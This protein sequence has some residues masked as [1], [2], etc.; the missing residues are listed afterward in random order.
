VL[1]RRGRTASPP[2][3]QVEPPAPPVFPPAMIARRIR[4]GFLRRGRTVSP[5]WAQVEPPAPPA[6]PAAT[7]ARR[8]RMGFWR[9]GRTSSPPWPQVEPPAP[10]AWPPATVVRRARA[11]FARRGRRLE[12]PAAQFPPPPRPRGRAGVGLWRRLRRI[13]FPWPQ[14][15]QPP[16]PDVVP[17]R[18][19]LSDTRAA[20]VL[21]S[22]RAITAY[23]TFGNTAVEP[24][25]Q[26]AEPD[27]RLICAKFSSPAARRL[28]SVT[29]RLVGKSGASTE[30]LVRL[31]VYAD[32][33]GLPGALVA[34]S[35]NQH[36]IRG[37]A[38][39]AWY[40][41]TFGGE[42]L[43]AADYWLTQ[44]YGPAGSHVGP[45]YN[46]TG[47]TVRWRESPS[48]FP[49]PPDPLPAPTSTLSWR[50][51]IYAAYTTG[52]EHALLSSA[53]AG[54]ALLSSRTG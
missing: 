9:R 43:A 17:G 8:I 50:M 6:F 41:F 11:G 34:V 48:A 52:G 18:A 30:Q 25:K 19:L 5:P 29:T 28:A 36:S 47:G 42:Q 45:V 14:Q 26:F 31:A 2:W 49:A 46:A 27:G 13:W 33:A 16:A 3:P 35:A 10:P 22:V 21:L 38:A 7:V 32:A 23:A 39:E 4:L 51:S 15:D 54:L 24:T 53:P 44:F 40:E 37:D 20:V 12:V 1:L